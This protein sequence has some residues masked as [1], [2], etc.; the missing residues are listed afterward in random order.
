[1][2]S[3][4]QVFNNWVFYALT[5]V[6]LF[7]L[8]RKEPNAERPYRIF[9]Y[10]LVPAIFVAATLWLLVEVVVGAPARSLLGLGVI[11][12]ALPVYRWRM[13]KMTAGTP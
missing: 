5:G 12:L 13:R 4:F 11:A 6:T 10:P 8:R 9:G 2:L 1:V 7:V 3:D